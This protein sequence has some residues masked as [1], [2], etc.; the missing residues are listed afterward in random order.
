MH[1]GNAGGGERE[2]AIA[3]RFAVP[4]PRVFEAWVEPRRLAQWWGPHGFTNPL[5]ELDVRPG[6]AYRIVMRDAAGVDYPV[7]GVYLEVVVPELLVMTDDCS[8][9]PPEWH[10]QLDFGAE[11]DDG[12]PSLDSLSR[13]T[14]VAEDDRTLLAIRTLFASARICDA[15]LK[16]GMAEDWAQ[17]L[18]RLERH[19]AG[20]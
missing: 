19:L 7:R 4:R 8:E 1:A 15:M 14:F 12:P 18:E 11:E 10:A 3:R 2:F 9:H 17:S 5:C 6:G 16:M 13:V 20:G